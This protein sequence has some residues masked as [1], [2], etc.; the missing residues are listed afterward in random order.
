M[1][2]TVYEYFAALEAGDADRIVALFS[3]DGWV[4]SPLLGRM[5]A[6][7]FFP[8]V[9]RSSGA[10]KLTVHDVLVSTEGHPRAVGYFLYEWWL[11]DGA[12]VSFECADVFNFAPSTGRIESM[13]ILYDTHPIR[14]RVVDKYT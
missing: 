11:K 7:E 13:I 6:R 1:K 8:K 9:V 12:K 2:K 5:G 10:T 14:A 3:T 4:V